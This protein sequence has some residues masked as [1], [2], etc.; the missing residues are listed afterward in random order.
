MP[1]NAL[2][3]HLNDALDQV[4]PF[5]SGDV[6]ENLERAEELLIEAFDTLK[7]CLPQV[8]ACA[9][10]PQIIEDLALLETTQTQTR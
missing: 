7:Q 8:L 10:A 1:K 5:L 9:I 6:S 3:R 2:K 4:E